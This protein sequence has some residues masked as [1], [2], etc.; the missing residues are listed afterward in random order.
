[1]S[2]NSGVALRASVPPHWLPRSQLGSGNTHACEER[3]PPCAIA[4]VPI[5]QKE[6]SGSRSS[7]TSRAQ[8][9]GTV[10]GRP[11]SPPTKNHR[12]QLGRRWNTHASHQAGYPL[13]TTRSPRKSQATQMALNTGG[14]DRSKRE[15]RPDQSTERG[16]QTANSKLTRTPRKS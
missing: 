11:Q 5:P 4:S 15:S 2:P 6:T 8:I 14:Y 3:T 10:P 1:M 9:Q 12:S 7:I 16:C 13:N